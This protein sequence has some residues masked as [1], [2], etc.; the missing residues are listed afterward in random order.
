[1]RGYDAIDELYNGNIRPNERAYHEGTRFAVAM[2]AIA[3][4]EEWLRARLS[5][6]AAKRFDELMACQGDVTDITGRESFRTGF[7]LGV[8][9]MIDA[10]SKGEDM[11]YEL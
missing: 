4:H 9:L 5:D 1:M 11:L 7:Q 2:E 10:V 8:L 6:E 3:A